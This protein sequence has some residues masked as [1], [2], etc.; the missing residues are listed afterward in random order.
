MLL[1]WKFHVLH[2]DK[3]PVLS[4]EQELGLE[5][6][7]FEGLALQLSARIHLLEALFTHQQEVN[8]FVQQEFGARKN[9]TKKSASGDN[10]KN[11]AGRM[12]A[13]LNEKQFIRVVS[14]VVDVAASTA[15]L[16]FRKVDAN[17]DFRVSWDEL[18]TYLMHENQ[19][20]SQ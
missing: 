12:S 2:I 10:P 20:V 7:P 4:Q 5:P 13:G 17:M 14:Q 3:Q 19:Q 18:L 8:K 1:L 6:T 15:S 16:L 11:N 9:E